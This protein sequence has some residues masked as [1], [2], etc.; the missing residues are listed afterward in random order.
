MIKEGDKLIS[1]VNIMR[2]D[3]TVYLTDGKMY[4]VGDILHNMFYIICD[5]DLVRMFNMNDNY[6]LLYNEW[7]AL[8]REKHIKSILDD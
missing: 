5:D 8:E 7:L 2:A 4:V 3:S 6:F 1:K